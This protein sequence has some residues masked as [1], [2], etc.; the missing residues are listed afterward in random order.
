MTRKIDPEKKVH[1]RDIA[2]V[3]HRKDTS[4][5]PHNWPG[6][7]SRSQEHEAEFVRHGKHEDP[8]EVTEA[9]RELERKVPHSDE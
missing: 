9:Q 1:P 6:I 5:P 4:R 2:D 3:S 7:P 8:A